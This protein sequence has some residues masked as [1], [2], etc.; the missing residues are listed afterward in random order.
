MSKFTERLTGLMAERNM[1]PVQLAKETGLALKTI[2]TYL[3]G[4]GS[5]KV[6]NPRA[7]YLARL[8]DALDVSMD[9]LYGRSDER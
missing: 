2:Y 5:G 8:A 6:D 3:D 9:Y 4:Y 7:S 1:A